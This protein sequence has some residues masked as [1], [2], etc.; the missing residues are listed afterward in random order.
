M[1]YDPF[2]SSYRRDPL[3]GTGLGLDG[4]GGYGNNDGLA[5][6]RYDSGLDD[7]G[8]AGLDSYGSAALD[9]GLGG[10]GTLS[11]DTDL[12][13]YNTGL[14]GGGLDGLGG[15]DSGY[16]ALGSGLSGDFSIP[17]VDGDYLGEHA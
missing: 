16:G 11:L 6:Q 9:G 12:D 3:D 13:G 1:S 5:L 4:L 2:D 15:Y 7:L 17:Q 8:G 10:L 14:R